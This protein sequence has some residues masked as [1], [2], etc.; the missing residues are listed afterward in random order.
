MGR[1]GCFLLGLLVG[2]VVMWGSLHYHFIIADQGLHVVPKLYP[3]FA[4][5]IVDIR[6]YG[7]D[8]WQQHRTLAVAIQQAGK[9]ELLKGVIPAQ[10]QGPLEGIHDLL[11]GSRG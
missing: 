4:D 5:S 6:A 3:A 7:F 9:V 2:A 8:E 10:M 1:I 11:G